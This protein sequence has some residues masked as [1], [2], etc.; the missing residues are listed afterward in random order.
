V[1]AKEV[2]RIEAYLRRTLNPAIRL[3]SRPRVTDSVEVMIGEE[4]VGVVYL[5]E[6]EG[7]IS[8]QLQATILQEDLDADV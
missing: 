1:N 8:Y 7:E 4:H 6:D 5:I 2:A 3:A